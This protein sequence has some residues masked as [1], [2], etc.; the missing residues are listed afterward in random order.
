MA[1][2]YLESMLGDKEKILTSARQH[3]FLLASSV[4][5]EIILIL[6]LL[7]AIVAAAILKPDLRVLA[8]LIGFGLMLIPIAS[9]TRD[10]LKWG[11]NQY[12]ITNWRVIQVSGIIEKTVTDSSLEKVNDVKLTQS[13]FGRL[14]NYGDIE[15][16]TASETGVDRFKNIDHPI[17]FKTSLQNARER[18]E[19]GENFIRRELSSEN[20]KTDLP[21][22][23]EQ[24]AVLR[25]QGILTEEEFQTK[26]KEILA[27]F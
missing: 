10:I 12:I 20:Q 22:M 16:M 6:I 7:V 18:L 21:G 1:Q 11:N 15:I 3:K 5:L 8:V 17:K 25:K 14:F 19:S 23:I 9:L 13:V 4:L 2:S 26:K 27:R 24:L